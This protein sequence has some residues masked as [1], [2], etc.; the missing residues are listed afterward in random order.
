M[1]R[2]EDMGTSN[3][4]DNKLG[5]AFRIPPEQD[6]EA[7]RAQLQVLA[8]A[9]QIYLE[10]NVVYRDNWKQ[11]GWK[12]PLVRAKERVDRLWDKFWMMPLT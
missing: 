4:L 10:R 1:S 6:L 9:F 8:D 5:V 3:P 12:Q 11:A 7:A 2:V